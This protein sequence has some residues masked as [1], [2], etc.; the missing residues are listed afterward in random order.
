MYIDNSLS[1][2][3]MQEAFSLLSGCEQ[4]KKQSDETASSISKLIF[5]TF[6]DSI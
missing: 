4:R 6:D 1:V 3:N 2:F 5:V